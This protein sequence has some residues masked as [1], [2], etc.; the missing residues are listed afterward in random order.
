MSKKT[1]DMKRRAYSGEFIQDQLR[2]NENEAPDAMAA[3]NST[4]NRK[5]TKEIGVEGVEP[6]SN[7]FAS[8]HM[9]DPIINMYDFD[10][11]VFHRNIIKDADQEAA[12]Q[13]APEENAEIQHCGPEV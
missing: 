11:T 2:S 8:G 4:P 10:A 3:E 5:A 7:V 1:H 9:V 12:D 13:E 6:N